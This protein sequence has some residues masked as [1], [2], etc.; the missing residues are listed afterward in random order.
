MC[1][2]RPPQRK[3]EAAHREAHWKGE[4][5]GKTGLHHQTR[6]V[7]SGSP[8]AAACLPIARAD[9]L[10]PRVHQAGEGAGGSVRRVQ[11]HSD[12]RLFLMRGG[13]GGFSL[14]FWPNV[15][16]GM[17]TKAVHKSSEEEKK[18]EE[19]KK[20][21]EQHDNIVTQYKELIREQVNSLSCCAVV[22]VVCGCVC[23][24][25]FIFPPCRPAGC[26][27]AAAEGAGVVPV[28]SERADAEHHHPAAVPDPA[29]QGPVQH[30]QAQTGWVDGHAGRQ[31]A[32]DWTEFAALNMAGVV[33]RAC[34]CHFQGRTTRIREK[35]HT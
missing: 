29:A 1:R 31:A 22:V 6:A 19:V 9:A 27:G 28:L 10:R 12:F 32:C 34:V 13:R 20:T 2:L 7:F 30:P 18:E 4:L 35:P 17:I 21:L 5:C 25:R 8:E 24:L 16:T 33:T 14:D 11:Q 15:I 3:A 23:V 26:P